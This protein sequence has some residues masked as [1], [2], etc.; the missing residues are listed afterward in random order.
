MADPTSAALRR[1]PLPRSAKKLAFSAR[2]FF[3]TLL[4]V[5][6]IAAVSLFLHA[7]ETVALH[8]ASGLGRRGLSAQDEEV[9][10][11]SRRTQP[12]ALTGS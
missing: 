3:T 6:A 11:R 4:V 12:P 9:S 2:P 8:D 5:C 1:P 7:P 10:R